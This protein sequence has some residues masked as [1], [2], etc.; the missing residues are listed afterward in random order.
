VISFLLAA[1]VSPGCVG[2]LALYLCI[3]L[4]YSFR[5]KREPIIDVFLLAT[6][7]SMRLALGVVVAGAVFS[8][9]LFVFS[10]F[11]FL[12]LSTAKRQTEITRM[13]MHGLDETPGR[14]Y[15][16]SDAPLI[17]SLGVGSMMAT[18]LIMVIYLV[19][20]AFPTGFYKHP[21]FL[22]SFPLIIFLWLARIWLLC[23]RGEL[24]DDPVAFA[25]KDKLSLCYGLLM[26]AMFGAALL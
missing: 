26:A 16:A 13:V 12:S 20:D 7:F 6:L 1:L 8:P 10:M 11:M 15:R 25:L 3:S 17:L 22:W 5:L 21:H 14:G 18:V 19:E 4:A 2:M 23:H 24:H 9:W